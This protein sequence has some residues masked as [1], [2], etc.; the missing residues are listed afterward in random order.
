MVFFILEN[1]VSFLPIVYF[2]VAGTI[3]FYQI[4]SIG[5]N[6]VVTYSTFF[7]LKLYCCFMLALISLANMIISIA[8]P[9]KVD[10][11]SYYENC[12]K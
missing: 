3:N 1:V 5:F 11:R 2:L 8:D 10:K 9:E 12:V 6:R 4:R 7:K